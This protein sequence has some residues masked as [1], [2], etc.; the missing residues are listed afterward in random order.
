ML[1]YADLDGLKEINDT[2]GHSEGSLAIAKT[3]EVLRQ[4]FR[5]S[6][7]VS[8]LGGDEFA[9]LA[10]NVPTHEVE[11]VIARLEGNL[12]T[13]NKLN[14][15]SYQLSLSVGTVWIAH[16]SNLSIDQ[17]VDQA[18]HAMYDH[19]RSKKELAKSIVQVGVEPIK[20]RRLRVV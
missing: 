11:T 1:L 16:D 2:F 12:C 15:H 5:N 20:Y 9:I 18:D 10:Q 14:Q 4:T 19:K 17:L 6:D 13:E 7:I 3:A 8:R